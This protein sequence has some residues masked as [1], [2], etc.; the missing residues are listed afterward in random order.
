MPPHIAVGD[1]Q[2]RTLARP[3]AWPALIIIFLIVILILFRAAEC[4]GI[5]ITIK[6]KIKSVRAAH[7][8]SLDAPRRDVAFASAPCP[9]IPSG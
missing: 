6:K 4:P 1:A 2:A 3:D 5:K 8:F 9:T 7:A